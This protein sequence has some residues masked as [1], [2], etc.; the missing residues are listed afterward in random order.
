MSWKNDIRVFVSIDFG[1]T[2]SGFAYAHK[3]NPE[4]I[5][6]DS[7]PEQIGA[8]K[9]NTVLQYDEKYQEVLEW[10]YPALAQKP[11]RKGRKKNIAYRPIE[12]FKLHL[13]TMPDSEKPL[14]PKL[15]DYKKAIT[16]YLREMV[17]TVPA[18]YSEKSKGILRDCAFNA[19]LIGHL[20]SEKL[21]FS[22]EPEA[23]AIHCMQV[24]NEHFGTPEGKSFLIVDCGGGTVDLT[25]RKFMSADS[26]GEVTERTGDFCGST[27]VDKEFIKLL[28][29]VAGEEAVKILEEQHYGQM[30]YMIQEF[31]RKVKFQ[32]TGIVKDFRPYEFDLEEVCPA[33]KQCVT[34]SYK[35]K[36]EEDEW[37]IDLDFETVK[38][39]FDPMIGRIIRLIS[40][41]LNNSDGCS[42]MF[43]VGGFSESKYLQMRVREEFAGKVK[44]IAVPKQPQA[45]IVRGALDYG[46]KMEIIKT[47]VLKYTYGIETQ[48]LFGPSDPPE[49]RVDEKYIYKF[50]KLVERGRE[51]GVDESF[52]QVFRPLDHT[53]KLRFTVYC[54]KAQ[55]GTYC[56]EE[57]MSLL[58]EI[59]VDMPDVQLKKERPIDFRLLFGRMEITAIAINQITSHEYKSTFKLDL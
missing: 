58:G 30:Q 18:E 5:T 38:S 49:R 56:N 4:I 53:T 11:Q 20:T 35:E 31:C 14:L 47:R 12:L 52:G 41:Q 3:Q 50:H 51:V 32:F 42:V 25:T 6:N 21:Q 19:G 44:S 34:G 24:L 33:I 9:T 36:L 37:I 54:T 39:L 45:A 48:N 7:W 22:T 17:L 23:A 10:G 27:Y 16:D 55:N 46:I 29:R 40:G 57:G 59:I 2:Y 43:L 28:K 13:G 8:L 1:T 26:L 15:L